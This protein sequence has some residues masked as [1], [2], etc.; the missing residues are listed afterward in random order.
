MME[1]TLQRKV[2]DFNL[3]RSISISRSCRILDLVSEVGEIAKIEFLEE[4]NKHQDLIKWQDELGDVLYSILCL[5]DQLN[6]DAEQILT[7][8]LEKY[9]CRFKLNGSFGSS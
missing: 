5:I 6:L 3:N 9:E 7:S 1:N 8:S 2:R 4:V